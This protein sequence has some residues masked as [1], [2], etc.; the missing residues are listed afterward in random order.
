[1]AGYS[2]FLDIDHYTLGVVASSRTPVV[3]G[4]FVLGAI[5]SPT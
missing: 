4:T 1:M 5:A 2:S 3:G